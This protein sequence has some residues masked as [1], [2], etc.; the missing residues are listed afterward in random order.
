VVAFDGRLFVDLERVSPVGSPL[1]E[2]EMRGIRE[3]AAGDTGVPV[4]EVDP[5]PAVR[6]DFRLVDCELECG[7]RKDNFG[8]VGFVVV[9]VLLSGDT[10]ACGSDLPREWGFVPLG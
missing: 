9:V 5:E 7:I 8:A 3:E 4:P 2:E 10:L 6:G 1:A